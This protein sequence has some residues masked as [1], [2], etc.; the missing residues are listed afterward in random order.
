M[1]RGVLE[2]SESDQGPPKHIFVI[3]IL[4]DMENTISEA[5]VW[6]PFDTPPECE[7]L[8][9]PKREPPLWAPGPR[10]GGTPSTARTSTAIVCLPGR[11]LRDHES[12][13]KD[14]ERYAV[15]YAPTGASVQYEGESSPTREVDKLHKN[16]P[17]REAVRSRARRHVCPIDA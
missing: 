4:G 1:A 2:Y 12:Q 11:G 6:E 9:G 15:R 5:N 10:A 16:A 13:A 3:L 8:L 17:K 14:F 7:G